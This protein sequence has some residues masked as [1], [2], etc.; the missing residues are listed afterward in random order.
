MLV[1]FGV[2]LGVHAVLHRRPQGLRPGLPPWLRD[3]CVYL[4][5]G[6]F[7]LAMDFWAWDRVYP[8]F[9]GVPAWM[10]YFIGLSGLQTIVMLYMLQRRHG[11]DT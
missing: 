4:Q 8:V 2:Y 11:R 1:S 9:M 7:I 3:P 5:A 6:I 10:G